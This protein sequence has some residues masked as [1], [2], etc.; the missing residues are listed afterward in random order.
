MICL[1]SSDLVQSSFKLISSW[2][3]LRVSL[4]TISGTISRVVKLALDPMKLGSHL[5]SSLQGLL[6]TKND[7]RAQKV[8]QDATS[9][10]LKGSNDLPSL[11]VPKVFLAL[12]GGTISSPCRLSGYLRQRVAVRVEP[13]E[14]EKLQSRFKEGCSAT[15]RTFYLN[16]EHTC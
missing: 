9:H 15:L 13:W 11:T 8:L 16:S 7:G 1:P 6:R 10:R 14:V 2:M 5:S 3:Y 4:K 12:I